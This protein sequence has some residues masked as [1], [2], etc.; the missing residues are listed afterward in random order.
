MWLRVEETELVQVAAAGGETTGTAIDAALYAALRARAW[1]A[2]ADD[3]L[4]GYAA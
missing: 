4:P 3:P 2:A 1:G